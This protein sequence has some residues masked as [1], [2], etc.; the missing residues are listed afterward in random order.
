MLIT[1]PPKKTFGRRDRPHPAPP[2]RERISDAL[3]TVEPRQHRRSIPAPTRAPHD[4]TPPT[5]PEAATPDLV[6]WTT[7]D[8]RSTPTPNSPL[9]AGTVPNRSLTDQA[10]NQLLC[11]VLSA[12]PIREHPS[13]DPKQ[14][15]KRLIGHLVKASPR[16]KKNIRD[17]I[18]VS[19]AAR[20]TADARTPTPPRHTPDTTPQT[21]PDR[22]PTKKVS[23]SHTILTPTRHA[24]PGG[25]SSGAHPLKPCL[26]ERSRTRSRSLPLPAHTGSDGLGSRRVRALRQACVRSMR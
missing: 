7:R 13:R 16:H 17:Q 24:A 18:A 11:S 10:V 4:S 1:T 22:P 19:V 23:S 26:S 15:R 20:P 2:T 8:A 14:P 21:V 5:R 12:P 6:R 25:R 3:E 9:A